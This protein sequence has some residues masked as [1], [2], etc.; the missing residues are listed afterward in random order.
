[1]NEP[2]ATVYDASNS[3]RLAVSAWSH[4]VREFWGYRELT[5]RLMSRNFAAQFRQSFLGYVW[6]VLPPVATTRRLSR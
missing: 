5:W 4:M 1:M 6:V 2:S 3:D